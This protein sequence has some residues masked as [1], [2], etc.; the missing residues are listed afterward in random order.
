MIISYYTRNKLSLR[1][2]AYV[3]FSVILFAMSYTTYETLSMTIEMLAYNSDFL[4]VFVIPFLNMYNGKRGP[5]TSFNKYFFYVFY[6][7]HLWIISTI[8]YFLV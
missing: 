4:F 3:I 2:I 8:A 7:A 6:P 5:N 1:N